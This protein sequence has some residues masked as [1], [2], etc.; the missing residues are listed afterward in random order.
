MRI[1]APVAAVALLLAVDVKTKTWAAS[2]LRRA[3]PR[4][5]ADG[6]VELRY[7]ENSGIAFGLLRTNPTRARGPLLLGYSITASVVVGLL[8][9]RRLLRRRATGG[10]MTAGLSTLLAGTLGNLND[11]LERGR[12]IDF[13]AF[14]PSG[15]P[16]W[17][18]FNFADAFLAM[19]IALCA[20]AL[21]LSALGR[22][23]DGEAAAA[24]RTG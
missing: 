24:A 22:R 15:R 3:G 14:S 17:P 5:M 7:R 4:K 10:L 20:I 19:G 21:V 8:L 9:A 1:L 12:V 23:R 16:A 18:A 6:H 13:I 11:R 2:E